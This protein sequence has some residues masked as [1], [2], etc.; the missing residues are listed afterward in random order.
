MSLQW[1]ET[2]HF[3]KLNILNETRNAFIDAVT[4]VFITLAFSVT[5][6]I[7]SKQITVAYLQYICLDSEYKPH[8]L[9]ISIA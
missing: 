3:Q 6:G 4:A 9:L 1:H 2:F 7:F 8:T 5:F